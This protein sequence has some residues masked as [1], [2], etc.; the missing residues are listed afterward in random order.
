[1][2]LATN[3]L[4]GVILL[5]H[6]QLCQ[7]MKR[8]DVLIGSLLVMQVLSYLVQLQGVRTALLGKQGW[9]VGVQQKYVTVKL[10]LVWLLMLQVFHFD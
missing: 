4:G 8:L 1:M 9:N 2:S 6:V 3:H 10:L 5:E 7:G